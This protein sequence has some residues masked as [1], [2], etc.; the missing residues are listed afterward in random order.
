MDELK[1]AKPSLVRIIARTIFHESGMKIDNESGKTEI[2]KDMDEFG[3]NL[4]E[5]GEKDKKVV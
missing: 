3:K 1:Y 2:D 5:S 4:P